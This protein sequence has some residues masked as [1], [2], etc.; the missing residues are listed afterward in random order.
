MNI[1]KWGASDFSRA[2]TKERTEKFM[3]SPSTL[4]DSGCIYCGDIFSLKQE[5]GEVICFT[6]FERVKK[7][8]TKLLLKE[9]MTKLDKCFCRKCDEDL[10]CFHAKEEEHEISLCTD[11]SGEYEH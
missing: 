4:F 11:C 1:A 8:I 3:L 7:K 2:S 5:T 9:V 10:K 6:C